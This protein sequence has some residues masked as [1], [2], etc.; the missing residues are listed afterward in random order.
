MRY[1]RQ[2]AVGRTLKRIERNRLCALLLV[3][4]AGFAAGCRDRRAVDLSKSVAPITTV[5]PLPDEAFRVEWVSNTV[6][7]TLKVGPPAKVFVTIKNVSSVTWPDPKTS[8]HQPP[9]TGAVRLAYRWWS[10]TSP[11][12]TIDYSF[13]T[14]LEKPLAPGESATLRVMLK[15]PPQPGD[16]R[17]QFDLVQELAAWFE[18]KGAARLSVPVRVE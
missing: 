2:V 3:C 4:G 6:P 13:R 10:P 17:V 7:A 14:D 9:G 15:A 18:D 8:G 16:Y 11:L 5:T 12:P 1:D